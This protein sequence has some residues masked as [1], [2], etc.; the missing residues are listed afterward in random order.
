MAWISGI[1]L[2]LPGDSNVQVWEHSC[3]SS[4]IWSGRWMKSDGS[5][6]KAGEALQPGTCS[7]VWRARPWLPEE[8]A[9]LGSK[10]M[11]GIVKLCPLLNNHS[12]LTLCLLWALVSPS[13][14][15]RIWLGDMGLKHTRQSCMIAE[16]MWDVQGHYDGTSNLGSLPF[17]SSALLQPSTKRTW[18]IKNIQGI[19]YMLGTRCQEVNEAPEAVRGWRR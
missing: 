10:S 18:P 7:Q 12:A 15:S 17:T 14:L 16:K 1:F 4:W 8:M 11:D 19:C 6:R 3:R 2:T 13:L 5:L 9:L